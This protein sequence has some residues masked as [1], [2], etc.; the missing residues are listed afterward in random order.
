M[1]LKY[2]LYEAS[3]QT[4][5]V[6]VSIFKQ[7]FFEVRKRHPLVLREDFCG[8]FAISRAWAAQSSRHR[9]IGIDLAQEPLDY[10]R[11]HTDRS[12]RKR[13]QLYR[14]DVCKHR[15]RA[16]I[17]VA[18]NFSFCV[19]KTEDTLLKYFKNAERSLTD[20][21]I[22]VLEIAGGP[23]MIEKTTD[24]RRFRLN[25]QTGYTY[26]WEQSYFDPITT[27]ARY[28][29][30]FQLP[31]GKKLKNAFEYDWRLWSIP[32]LRSLLERSGFESADVYWEE[33]D[34]SGEGSG[35]YRRT[36]EG[37]NDYA[38]V[39]YVVGVKSGKSRQRVR[40]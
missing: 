22:L 36:E 38:W 3:V 19:F 16:E 31:N 30:H 14:E 18:C 4:P 24:R 34:D 40:L 5:D 17:A 28:A 1:S 27:Q 32:E 2:S 9:A 26:F 10:G 37:S 12:I 6:H 29:I 39:A 23:G 15:A 25:G 21:G 7:M 35:V 11:A 20:D 33:T 8:T 13:I